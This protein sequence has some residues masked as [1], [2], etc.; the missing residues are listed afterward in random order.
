LE[1]SQA[2]EVALEVALEMEE[3]HRQA[4]TVEE[5]SVEDIVLC[6]ASEL[7]IASVLQPRP[8][9]SVA[10]IQMEDGSPDEIVLQDELQAEEVD[11]LS[12]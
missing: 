12:P 9:C 3:V 8:F 11:S 5:A 4:G 10:R 6:M 7:R 2:L 1:A